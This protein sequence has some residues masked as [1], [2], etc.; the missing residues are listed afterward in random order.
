MLKSFLYHFYS[1]HHLPQ[2]F[3]SYT[4]RIMERQCQIISST[5]EGIQQAATMLQAGKC[6]AFPTGM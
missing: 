6:V 1:R 4:T 2:Q 3:F 5:D